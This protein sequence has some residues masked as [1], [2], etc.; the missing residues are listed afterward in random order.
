MS[1]LHTEDDANQVQL[2]LLRLS[3]DKLDESLQAM[4]NKRAEFALTIANIKTQML[5]QNP[6][7]LDSLQTFYRP[8]REAYVLQQVMQRNVGPVRDEDMA[9]LFRE[10]MSV[11][12]AMEEPLKIAYLGPEGTFTHAAV[13]KHF[14]QSVTTLPLAAID[15]VFRE[16]EAR[17]VSY[18]IVPVENSTEGAINHTLDSFIESRVRICGEVEQRIHHNLLVSKTTLTDKITRV[19]S[20]QQSF[21]Q[22]RKWLDAHYPNVERIA[23]NSNAEAARRIQ[24]EWNSAAIAGEMAAQLYSLE[25]LHP[26]IEDRP[27]NSTRFLVIGN[28][29]VLPSG[30]DKTSIVVSM[31]NAPGALHEL[32]DPFHRYAIDLTRIET[33]PGRDRWAYVF[34][35]DFKGHQQQDNVEKALKEVAAKASDLK[36]LGS[37][38]VA[39]L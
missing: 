12:L 29:A 10:I 7:S 23:V 37:Y 15:E 20:H 6:E 2:N 36:I 5:E 38:P 3:I 25:I 24:G 27:D 8:E 13:F 22:C 14:G 9:R 17:A 33:R 34:F 11:C 26:S 39:V 18:G 32:L 31:K 4:I 28:E 19:Y 21:A 16:V 30:Q 35:I 1:E